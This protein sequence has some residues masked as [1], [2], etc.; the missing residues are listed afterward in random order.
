MA[1]HP[2]Y[3]RCADVIDTGN[4]PL[5]VNQLAWGE[6]VTPEMLDFTPADVA[7]LTA[8]GRH[9]NTGEWHTG[10]EAEWVYVERWG[11]RGRE[12]HGFID[13]ASRKLLQTG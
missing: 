12:F 7:V 1:A 10:P 3:L 6:G 2:L 8:D 13:S 5:V 4:G 11:V 9:A